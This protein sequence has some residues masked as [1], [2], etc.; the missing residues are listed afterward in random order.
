MGR[1]VCL[2]LI[3][4]WMT[5]RRSIYVLLTSLF[6][7]FNLSIRACPGATVGTEISLPETSQQADSANTMRSHEAIVALQQ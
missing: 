2:N 7:H 5:K 4:D 1:V 3:S 6:F